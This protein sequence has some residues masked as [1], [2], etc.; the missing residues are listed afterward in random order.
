[1]ARMFSEEQIAMANSVDIASFLQM[2]GEALIKS[3]KDMRWARHTSITVRGNRFYDWKAEAGGYPIAFV[4]RYFNYNFKQAVEFLLSNVGDLQMSVPYEKTEKAEFKLPEKNETLNR[5]YGYLLKTRFL[6][7]EIIDEFVRKGLIYED[8][9]Y[10]NAVFVGLDE[11]GVARHGHKRGTATYGKNQSFRGNIEGSDPLYPFHY[12]GSSNKV[13][14]FEAPI[15]MLSYISLN[16]ANWMENSYIALNGLSKI[17]LNHF[18][19]VHPNIN[20]IYLCLDHDIA[21]IEGAERISDFLNEKGSYTISCIRARNKDFNE[22][23]KEQNNVE[24]IKSTDSPKYQEAMKYVSNIKSDFKTIVKDKFQEDEFDSLFAKFYSFNGK[25]PRDDFKFQ[26]QLDRLLKMTMIHEHSLLGFSHPLSD[27]SPVWSYLKQDY[28]SYRDNG[29]TKKMFE[30]SCA[31]YKVP[32]YQFGM[33]EELGHA[34]GKEMRAS[35]AVLDS[36]FAKALREK[37]D[38]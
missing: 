31:Y 17:G 23:L 38:D 6:D 37:L 19:D 14:V 36:G 1:M 15:D 24:F 16:K 2:Q 3:G 22:D 28:R 27:D 12:K 5:V 33:K 30:N 25:E 9:E 32:V 4:Q 8:K 13:Y 7:K 18:L 26:A 29:N 11:N 35:L 20:Q 21:G 34:M 10:H